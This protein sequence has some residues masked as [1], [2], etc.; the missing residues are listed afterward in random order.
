MYPGLRGVGLFKLIKINKTL[1]IKIA[2][3]TPYYISYLPMKVQ[4]KSLRPYVGI[5]NAFN[6]K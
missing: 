4:S 2:L 6:Q 3:D 5:L 1:K